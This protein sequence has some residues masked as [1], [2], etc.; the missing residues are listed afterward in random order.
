MMKS[1]PENSF[2][3]RHYRR[4]S[5]IFDGGKSF[6]LQSA[7]LGHRYNCVRIAL[8]N[9]GSLSALECGVGSLNTCLFLSRFFRNYT[10]IDIAADQLKKGGPP[11]SVRDLKLIE[12]NL[13]ERWPFSEK[14]FDVV[15]AMMVFE[16]LFDPFHSFSETARILKPGGYAFVNLPIVTSLKNRLRLLLGRLPMTSTKEWWDL[17]EWDGGHLHFYSVSAIERL[18]NKYGLYMTAAF[19][20]GNW[21]R[22]KRVWPAGLCGELSFVLRRQ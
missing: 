2:Y 8:P 5:E 1:S 16:H 4:Q 14:R 6:E 21:P 12:H 13:N 3:T 17:E 22:L 20:C 18:S 19:P 15:L 9:P 7:Q 10:V 11:Q